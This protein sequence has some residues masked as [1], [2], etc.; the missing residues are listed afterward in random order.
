MSI[1]CVYIYEKLFILHYYLELSVES[2]LFLQQDIGI[3][4]PAF[5]LTFQ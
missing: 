4:I 3:Y 5:I 1:I 2:N